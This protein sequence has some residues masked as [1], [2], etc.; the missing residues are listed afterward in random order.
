MSQVYHD[1][2]C[3][4]GELLSRATSPSGATLLI[5]DLQRPYVWSPRQVVFLVDSL[6]RGWPFGT[7]LTWRVDARDPVRELARPFWS[8][9]DRT[10]A[11]AEAQ[12]SAKNPPS[13][14]QMV[15]DGQQRVQSLLLAMCGDAWGIRMF[16][17]EWQMALSEKRI[18]RNVTHWCQGSLC[19][20]MEALVTG[21]RVTRRI[22]ALDFSNVLAW[23]VTGGA[24]ACSQKSRK[25]DG[26]PLPLTHEHGMGGRYIRLSRFWDAAPEADGIEQEQANTIA[27][28]VLS[29]HAVAPERMD[30]MTAVSGALLM[31]LTRVKTTRVTFLELKQF[32]Q[33]LFTRDAY[34]DAVVNIFTRLNTAG[35][36]LT[37]EDITF[38]WLKS[39]WENL[40][41]G[42]RNASQCFE[43]LMEDLAGEKLVLSTEE[44]ISGVSYLWAAV[45]QDGRVLNN[46]DLL[47]G[48]KIKPMA[49]VLSKNWDLLT[50]SVVSVSKAINARGYL[51]HEHYQSLNSL[52][53]LWS[54]QYIADCWLAAHPMRELGEDAYVKRVATVRDELTD[55]WLFCSQWA[56]RWAIASAETITG[57]AK[58]LSECATKVASETNTDAA[59]SLL[60]EFLEAEVKALESDAMN[61]LD[62]LNV[63]RRE[64]VRVYYAPLWLWHRLD[65]ERWKASKIQLRVGKGGSLSLDV[66]HSV[67]HALW[68]DK[69]KQSLTE[70]ETDSDESLE[71]VNQIGNCSLL[72][73]SFNIIK[74][75]HSFRSFLVQVHEFKDSP[76]RLQE[77]AAALAIPTAMME[78]DT[79]DVTQIKQA[80]AHRDTLIRQD[81]KD[82]IQGKRVRVD[83]D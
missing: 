34:D 50:K 53:V 52:F 54:W 29:E 12:V 58:R 77:W 22:A 37:R 74:F 19:V 41:T 55:R 6:I 26:R 28:G 3:N 40:H 46:N 49:A 36:T 5:P 31:A 78:A 10:G 51:R 68:E 43:G 13:A 71:L 7:L 42:N 8:V 44:L 14:F 24:P 18:R 47:K 23:A 82:F 1:Q 62:A 81:L 56:G 38:A 20:D 83:L 63:R 79:S 59:L 30:E 27:A 66:D 45:H 2:H 61:G 11:D 75:K 4:L 25:G 64:L 16:D 67:A 70:G 76:G 21:Y 39:K 57:Y 73:K 69:L 17:S 33:R 32:D 80:I 72:E 65:A 15:L 48:E 35:R 60:G 9:V